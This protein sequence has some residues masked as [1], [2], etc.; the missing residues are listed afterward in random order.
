MQRWSRPLACLLLLGCR[1]ALAQSSPGPNPAP[2]DVAQ[3]AVAAAL[4][5]STPSGTLLLVGGGPIPDEVRRQFLEL[6][7]GPE[8]R[9]VI[10]PASPSASSARYA[11]MTMAPWRPVAAASVELLHATSRE[12]ADEPDFAEPIRKA[13]A[14]WFGGGTQGFL[15][16]T[17]AGTA[18]EREVR[19][20]LARG[21]VVGGTSAG[22]SIASRV[23]IVRGQKPA[24]VGTGL[25]LLE[26][27]IVDQHFLRRRRQDRLVDLVVRHPDQIGLGI[28]ESTAVVIPLAGR[29]ARV[30]GLSKVV[31]C[32]PSTAGDAPEIREFSPGDELPLDSFKPAAVARAETTGEAR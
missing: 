7:G 20:L 14:V 30:L 6:A 2:P 24:E 12:Q 23:M 4:P 10:I 11:E 22:A 15:A 1:T 19:A 25:G 9:I 13:T 31:A 17:Y 27:V 32:I 21:G 5:A 28:D 29:R 16:Q 18:V 8:A 3:A 26:D